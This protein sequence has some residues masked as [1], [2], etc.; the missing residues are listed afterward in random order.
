MDVNKKIKVRRQELGL[1]DVEVAKLAG[2]SI[3]EYS[4]I[5]MHV[6]EIMLYPGLNKVKE[7]LKILKIDFFDLFD[8][9]CVFCE[10]DKQYIK[11]YLLPR[12]ELIH[13]RR[14]EMGLSASD[15]GDRIG[16]EEVAVNDMEKDPNYLET[17]AIDYIK[18]LSRVIDV[19]LQILLNIKCTKCGR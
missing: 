8:M 2:L 3:H 11:D 10:K 5:E 19:P 14:T 9:H 18:D 7:V 13:K 12:N 4:D 16:F 17:W 1:T 15:L 6:D